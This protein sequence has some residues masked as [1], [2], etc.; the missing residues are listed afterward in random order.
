MK[1]VAGEVGKPLA[2]L[3]DSSSQIEE[4][5]GDWW[6]S[7]IVQKFKKYQ[8]NKC[9]SDCQLNAE[10]THVGWILHNIYKCI[11]WQRMV[12]VPDLASIVL[13]QPIPSQNKI[14]N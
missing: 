13:D 12:C 4:A 8:K 1:Q 2:N 6:M 14:A 7:N 3:M 10:S 9:D 11:I 5:P